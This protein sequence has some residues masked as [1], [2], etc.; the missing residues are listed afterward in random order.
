MA[1]GKLEK[2]INKQSNTG[3]KYLAVQID[4]VWGSFW[5][6]LDAQIG[7]DISYEFNKKGDFTNYTAISRVGGSAS[8]ASTGPSTSTGSGQRLTG[9]AKDTAITRMAVLRSAVQML[10]PFPPKKG[11]TPADRIALAVATA[12]RFR[13]YIEGNFTATPAE[14]GPSKEAVPTVDDSVFPTGD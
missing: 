1:Q 7:D 2:V 13:T 9:D 4:G 12:E 5:G 11:E 14:A 3:K 10:G 8:G 6:T